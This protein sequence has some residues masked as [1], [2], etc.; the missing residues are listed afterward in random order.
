VQRVLTFL[1][2]ASG[3]IAVGLF[4]WAGILMIFAGGNKSQ[5]EKAKGLF[6]NAFIGFIIVISA[7]LIVSTIIGLLGSSTTQSG[8]V[9]RANTLQE[10]S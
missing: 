3:I 2:Y 6:W 10:I 1:I 9:G 5:I 7:W 8:P 4:V